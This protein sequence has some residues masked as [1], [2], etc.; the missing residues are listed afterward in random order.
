[1]LVCFLSSSLAHAAVWETTHEQVGAFGHENLYGVS[2]PTR[3]LCIAVGDGHAILTS[4]NPAGDSWRV[5][6]PPLP[7]YAGARWD[8]KDHST[9]GAAASFQ[10]VSCPSEAFCAAVSREGD[11]Y[12]STDPAG[13]AGT[14]RGTD[15]DPNTT[16]QDRHLSAIDCPTSSFCVAVSEISESPRSGPEGGWILSSTDPAGGSGAWRSAQPAGNIDLEGVSCPNLNLCVAVARGGGVFVSRNPGSAN[17]T[18]DASGTPGGPGDLY[19]IDCTG[20][21]LCLTG[22]A[23]GNL[24]S[25]TTVNSPKSIW[26]EANGGRSVQIT[27]TSCASVTAC[28]AVDN[29]GN[30]TVSV[31]PTGPSSAWTSTNLLPFVADA[32]SGQPLNALFAVSCPSTELCVTVGAKGAILTSP[33]PFSVSGA[34]KGPASKQRRSPKRPRVVLT[35]GDQ[36]RTATFGRGVRVVFRFHAHGRTLGYECKLDRQPWRR[37][38]SPRRLYARVG[39]HRFRVRAIGLT[40]LSGPPT[41][42]RF[43]IRRVQFPDLGS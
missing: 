36:F 6:V 39:R 9:G 25:T 10:A 33:D 37:C 3:S 1:M 42:N 11:L 5:E 30:V 23:G 19:S 16:N 20:I 26:A 43:K 14:W 35:R 13:G 27:G 22:N 18:W 41:S 31:D 34:S 17:P 24:L 7:T 4:Q 8:E 28:D 38:R 2:C 21:A 12:T 40:G 29:N 15:L 32:P